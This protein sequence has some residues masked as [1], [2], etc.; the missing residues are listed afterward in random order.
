MVTR[1]YISYI[2]H[3]STGGGIFEPGMALDIDGF[4]CLEELTISENRTLWKEL[5][6]ALINWDGSFK[7]ASESLKKLSINSC[8]LP[9]DWLDRLDRRLAGYPFPFPN[10]Q[11]LNARG[12]VL[13]TSLVE[14]LNRNV[15]NLEILRWRRKAPC[16]SAICKLSTSKV[17]KN[18]TH[19]LSFLCH[20]WIN[21]Y[22]RKSCA[23]AMPIATRPPSFHL[24][25][26]FSWCSIR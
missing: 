20:I 24:D 9:R 13:T 16:F 21:K 18:P 5:T 6:V 7:Q 23:C 2:S 22:E 25:A 26:F 14:L 3:I 15:P 19:N 4:K 1:S 8:R 10:L 17:R 11:V 12:S